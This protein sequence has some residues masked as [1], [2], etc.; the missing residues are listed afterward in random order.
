MIYLSWDILDYAGVLLIWSII[1][2]FACFKFKGKWRKRM[3]L[4]SSI[5]LIAINMAAYRVGS[6]PEEISRERYNAAPP[7]IEHKI[8]NKRYS[9]SDANNDYIKVLKESDK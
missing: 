1:C 6:K 3:Y 7:A 8:V 5:A 2:S 4:L 9:A